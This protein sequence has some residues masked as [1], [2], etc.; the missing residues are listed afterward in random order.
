MYSKEKL[1]KGLKIGILCE[2]EKENFE[3]AETE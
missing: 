3:K 1:E 2:N